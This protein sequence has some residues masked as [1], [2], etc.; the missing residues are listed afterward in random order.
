MFGRC[1]E[2]KSNVTEY[3]HLLGNGSLAIVPAATNISKDIPMTTN[4]ITE[5]N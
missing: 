2:G 3:D 1:G 4:R 5:D